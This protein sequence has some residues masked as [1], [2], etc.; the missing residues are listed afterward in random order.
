VSYYRAGGDYYRGG[1]GDLFGTIGGLAKRALGM[2]GGPVGGVISA[3][4]PSRM[5]Q[6]PPVVSSP[7]KTGMKMGTD[8]MTDAFGGA[9]R[10]HRRMNPA[11]PKALKRALRREAAFIHLAQSTLKGTGYHISRAH[12]IPAGKK[13]H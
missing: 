3:A 13:K 11:N 12:R 1:R 5:P 2:F 6:L 8:M 9:H 7:F 10:K 4:L